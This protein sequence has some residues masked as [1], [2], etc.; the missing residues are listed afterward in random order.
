M[1]AQTLFPI[2][3]ARDLP[4]LVAFY[5]DLLGLTVV[6][7]YPATGEPVYVALRW[8]QATL[9][10]SAEVTVPGL[11]GRPLAP[12]Q[13]GRGFE[14][15]LYVPAVDRLV[16]RL[17]AQGVPVLVAPIEMPWGER[18]AYIRDPEG[19]VIMLTQPVAGGA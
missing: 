18:L 16:E 12:V 13:G 3:Y 7:R 14:L 10:I 1:S 8:G 15:C 6:Y 17:R 4:R 11:E 5:R 2:L 19:N 9:G